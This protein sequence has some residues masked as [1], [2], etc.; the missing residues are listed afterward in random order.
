MPAEGPVL[1]WR[2]LDTPSLPLTHSPKMYLDPTLGPKSQEM[3]PGRLCLL[4]VKE[5]TKCLLF[6]EGSLELSCC[7]SLDLSALSGDI[8]G[9]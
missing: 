2:V 1:A 7:C 6:E 4:P 9:C 3:V 5:Q 8:R